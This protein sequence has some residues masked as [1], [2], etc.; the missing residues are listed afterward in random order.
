MKKAL[1]IA[2][3]L[4]EAMYKMLFEMVGAD[5]GLGV[6]ISVTFRLCQLIFGLI[7]GVFLLLPGQR[8]ELRESEDDAAD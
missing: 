1:L 2:I 7:G 4:G 8:R 5:G 6:A 3:G